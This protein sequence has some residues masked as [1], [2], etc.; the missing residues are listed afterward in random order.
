VAAFHE[1]LLDAIASGD[2]DIAKR[3]VLDHYVRVE[4]RLAVRNELIQQI[5]GTLAGLYQEDFH[6]HNGAR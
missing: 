1:R 5:T 6:P 4:D 3:G 2:P